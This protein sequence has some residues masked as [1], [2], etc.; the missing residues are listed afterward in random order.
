MH[1]KEPLME[2]LH[3]DAFISYRHN[4]VDTAVAKELQHSLEHFRIPKAIREKTGKDR[5]NRI[6]RDE[7]ELEITSDLSKKL[8]DALNASDFLI[9][10]CSPRYCESQWCIHEVETFVSRKG[11]DRVLC[12]IAEG[13]PPAIFPDVLLKREETVTLQDGT[14]ETRTVDTEPLACD[15]RGDL[16]QARRIEL[17]RLASVMLDCSYDE[18]VLRQERYRRRRLTAILAG[19]FSLSAVAISYL[20]WS[21]AQISR[22][23]R[24]S[25]INESKMLARESINSMEDQDRLSALRHSLEAVG[26]GEDGRPVVDEALYSLSC[27]SYA[28]TLSPNYL[29]EWR[30]DTVNDITSF[31]LSEDAGVLV[32]LDRLGTYHGIDMN[33]HE[34]LYEYRAGVSARPSAPQT[35]SR[36]DVLFTSAGCAVS[37]DIRSGAELWS[38]PLQYMTINS[39]AVSPDGSLIAAAD[40]Y[41]VQ[42]M[43]P[44]GV[45]VLSLPLPDDYDGYINGLF[46]SGDGSEIGVYLRSHLKNQIGVFDYDTSAFSVVTDAHSAVN[47]AS[48]C[49]DGRLYAVCSDISSAA[50]STQD[51]SRVYPNSYRLY[52]ADKGQLMWSTDAETSSPVVCVSVDV[53]KD[54]EDEILLTLGSSVF[55]FSADGTAGQVTD[56]GEII[57]SVVRTDDGMIYVV[58]SEGR[59]GTVFPGSRSVYLREMF[60]ADIDELV[61]AGSSAGGTAETFVIRKDGNLSVYSDLSDPGAVFLG[62]T[63]FQY[64]PLSSLRHDDLMLLFADDMFLFYDI[65]SGKLIRSITMD[66]GGAYHL[67]TETDGTAHV[68]RVD[69]STAGISVCSYDMHTGEKIREIP[70]N[71]VEYYTASGL[72]GSDNPL[73]YILSVMDTLYIQ[74]SP[75]SVRGSLFCMHDMTDPNSL[76]LCDL[77]SGSV[78]TVKV[79]LDENCY[80]VDIASAI[81]VELSPVLISEDGSCVF[82]VMTDVSS[83]ISRAV[84]IS[85]QDG[86]VKQLDG[87]IFDLSSPVFSGGT[88][89]YSGT[90]TLHICSQ[91]GTPLSDIPFTGDNAL[92][93]FC[94]EGRQYCVF[95]D[96]DLVIYENGEQIRTVHLAAEVSAYINGK[97]FRYEFC[98]DRLYLFC[99]RDLNVISLDSDSTTPLYAVTGCAVDADPSDGR[100]ICFG[101]VSDGISSENRLLL[102]REY[103]PQEL[104]ARGREQLESFSLSVPQT[105]D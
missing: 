25:L 62:D 47:A 63:G 14:E 53:I 46:W 69:L 16:K 57:S 33:T 24:Q 21:N 35:G 29:E 26:Y 34:E 99:D 48:F 72:I 40:S 100:I 65:G 95:P 1:Q 55:S 94:H 17:P 103:T 3:Y 49:S 59:Y 7:E 32:A 98:N 43:S 11:L 44:E 27:A 15:Y 22:N 2:D 80:L 23:Y 42:V 37:L 13:E 105:A 41:A 79:Q 75:V 70:L 9:V 82:S 36:G 67:L 12:V 74:P 66:D 31:C 38:L 81:V 64:D 96:G 101:P 51:R 52:C 88:L 102:F 20:L 86:S 54:P 61:S 5:I 77:E 6:F 68:M 76:I 39:L 73:Y 97:A 90:D 84:T 89:M 50:G 87:D 60:P 28:Y 8:D 58:T 91:D 19:V 71:A 10:V 92:S 78:R 85:L 93:F 18:L 45:P 4:P 30:A 83:G 104:I 56:V